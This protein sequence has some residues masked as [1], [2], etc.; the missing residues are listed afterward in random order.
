MITCPYCLSLN[1]EGTLVCVTCSRDI[2]IPSTLVSERDELLRKRDI[3][4]QDLLKARREI[5]MIRS[6]KQSR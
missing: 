5:E 6:R 3:I 4:H 1:V 2:A